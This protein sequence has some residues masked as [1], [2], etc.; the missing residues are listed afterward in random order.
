MELLN[1]QDGEYAEGEEVN[2][3]YGGQSYQTAF[4]AEARVRG[5]CPDCKVGHV[6][7][8]KKRTGGT[9]LWPSDQFRNCPKFLE[10][11]PAEKAA[12]IE[13]GRGCPKSTS[14]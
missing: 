9:E 2:A 12:R 10:M 1:A 14:W 6:W 11:T 5:S 4:D 7:E 3:A 8:R 13:R